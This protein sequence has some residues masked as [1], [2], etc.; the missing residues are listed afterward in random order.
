ME[1]HPPCKSAGCT[2][3]VS[4][5]ARCAAASA[6]GTSACN[7]TS[8]CT[9]VAALSDYRRS[10]SLSYVRRGFEALFATLPFL[11]ALPLAAFGGL[12]LFS[13]WKQGELHRLVEVAQRTQLTFDLVRVSTLCM[14]L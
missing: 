11:I 1:G 14:H 4:A 13:L 5:M 3:Q 6:R 7:T 12:E 2:F 9:S 10:V 8:P